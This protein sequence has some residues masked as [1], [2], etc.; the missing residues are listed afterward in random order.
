MTR[1]WAEKQRLGNLPDYAK[2]EGSDIQQFASFDEEAR[3]LLEGGETAKIRPGANSGW[4]AAVAGNVQERVHQAEKSPGHRQTKE[5][6]STLT[7]LKI[8]AH[9]ASFHSR[10]IPAAVNYRIFERTRHPAA[11]AEAVRHERNA[12]QAW[13]D[14]TAAAGDFY[15]PDLMMGVRGADL[16]GHWKD[17]LAALENGLAALERRLAELN[18]PGASAPSPLFQVSARKGDGRAPR[19]KHQ[20]VHAAPLGSGIRITAEVKDPAGVKWVR[21]RYRSVNQHQDYATAPMH[22][23]AGKHRYEAV[24]PADQIN[25][26]WDWMYFIEVMD[27]DGNGAIYPDLET[28]TPYIVVKLQR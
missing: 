8:L 15:A 25:P 9:L 11:L 27:Q 13:R 5:F 22:P 14:L 20:P 10:R 7:D 12:I 3:L 2:A 16:C 18:P 24:I 19:V 17:E 6:D 1:G 28:A 21:V 23:V 26:R 4:F